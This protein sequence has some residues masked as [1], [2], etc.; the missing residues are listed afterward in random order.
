MK[1]ETKNA[2]KKLS[3]CQLTVV[4]EWKGRIMC[5]EF[6]AEWWWK[7][8]IKTC[9]S[10]VD[11]NIWECWA[12]QSLQKFSVELANWYLLKPLVRGTLSDLLH[13]T[14]GTVYSKKSLENR[15]KRFSENSLS[16]KTEE[17]TQN[18][19]CTLQKIIYF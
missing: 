14:D 9:F 17:I 19:C 15:D 4:S 10:N 2:K 1:Q 16:C 7:D 11:V 8:A 6:F 18:L 5:K 3:H 12:F 13:V